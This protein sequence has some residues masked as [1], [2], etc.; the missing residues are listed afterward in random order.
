M[1]DLDEEGNYIKDGPR[2]AGG[3]ASGESS[4]AIYL[5]EAAATNSTNSTDIDFDAPELFG[6]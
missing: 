2:C 4:D 1:Q 6:V 3:G 5:E